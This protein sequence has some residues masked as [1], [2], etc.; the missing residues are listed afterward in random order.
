MDVLLGVS[1][2]RAA[3][4]QAA[5]QPIPPAVQIRGLI[6]T[7]ASGTC[8]DPASLKSLGLSPTG[9]VPILTPSTG[10]LPHFC[11]QFD[12]SLTLLHADHRL[13]FDTVA[14]MESN[15]AAQGIHA[16]IGRDILGKCLFVYDGQAGTFTLAF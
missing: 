5:A 9:V 11:N 7:G 16:L 12:V 10:N 15:L 3:A 8:I 2:A 4:L 1:G 6:D 14:V 13:H